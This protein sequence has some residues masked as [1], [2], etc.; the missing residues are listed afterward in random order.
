MAFPSYPSVHPIPDR[1]PYAYGV[2]M[3]VV[4]SDFAAG[5]SRQRRGYVTMPHLLQLTFHLRV[6]ELYLWQ[7]WINAYGYSW[8]NLPISTMY[9]GGP[10]VAS[11]IRYE[12]VRFVSDLAIAMDGW[13]WVSV[14]VS[15]EMSIDA[16][17]ADQDNGAG[18]GGW[19]IGGRPGSPSADWYIGGS[20]PLPSPQWVKA[21]TPAFPSSFVQE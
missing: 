14:A 15:A 17:A 20:P 8:F 4:R 11:N 9:A 2:D 3:G 12:V 10:P 6:E 7:R 19:V 5:N 18:I 13:N 1:A 16:W 21:G